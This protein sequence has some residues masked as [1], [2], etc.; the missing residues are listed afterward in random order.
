[1]SHSSFYAPSPAD[2]RQAIHAQINEMRGW[3]ERFSKA[4]ERDEVIPPPSAD[5]GAIR[6]MSASIAAGIGQSELEVDG[7]LTGGWLLQHLEYVGFLE[8][9]VAPRA[10]SLDPA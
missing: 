1:M 5:V 10:E 3:Y 6:S 4:I 2:R 8:N 9:W 7:I